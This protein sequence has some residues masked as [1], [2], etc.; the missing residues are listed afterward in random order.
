MYRAAH[1]YLLGRKVR[2][3]KLVIT[4]LCLSA[5][6]RANSWTLVCLHQTC[7]QLGG[8]NLDVPTRYRHGTSKNSTLVLILSTMKLWQQVNDGSERVFRANIMAWQL[9][10]AVAT[11]QV[12]RWVIDCVNL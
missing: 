12:D 2:S 9:T 8:S 7:F 10:L 3:N 4:V 11:G 6:Y 5:L 1:K